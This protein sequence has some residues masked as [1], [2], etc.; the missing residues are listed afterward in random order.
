V[1]DTRDRPVTPTLRPPPPRTMAC[2]APTRTMAAL[3]LRLAAGSERPEIFHS[4]VVARRVYEARATMG[5]VDPFT[6]L[7]FG[8]DDFPVE[9]NV[10]ELVNNLVR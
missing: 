1:G 4:E 2:W 7:G 8:W 6:G 10:N 5:L 3:P 9:K